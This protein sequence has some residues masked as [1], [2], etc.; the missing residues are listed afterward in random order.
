MAIAI[1]AMGAGAGVGVGNKTSEASTAQTVSASASIGDLVIVTIWADNSGT[2]GVSA[3]SS[4]TDSTGANT[5]TSLVE[6]SRPATT[7]AGLT[8]AMYRSVLASAL[9]SG[10]S[11][12]TVNW[13][14]N[15]VAKAVAVVKV[16][17]ADTTAYETGANDGSGTTYTV[18]TTASLAVNDVIL[19]S[20]GNESGTNVSLDTDSTNGTWVGSIGGTT[21]G[22]S[23]GDATKV[24]GRNQYKIATGVG[25]QTYDAATG[26]STDWAAVYALFREPAAATFAPPFRHN[27]RCLIVR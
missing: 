7:D 23:G 11:T 13:S 24:G 4:V 22:G 25:T 14:P 27:R 10:V 15:V 3:I 6:R 21:S 19:G 16:T 18:T 17:G 9:T 8:V 26:A 5:Y 12:V 1:T 2:S 20:A